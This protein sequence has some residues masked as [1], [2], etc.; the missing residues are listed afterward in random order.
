MPIATP[1]PT[2]LGA[3]YE[4]NESSESSS[5][6]SI[7]TDLPGGGEQAK[8]P[9]P[10]V[11]VLCLLR[12]LLRFA[13]LGAVLGGLGGVGTA[14]LPSSVKAN[15]T[16]AIGDV[17]SVPTV[18]GRLEAGLDRAVCAPAKSELRRLAREL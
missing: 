10:A 6:M 18:L 11:P 14:P 8:R 5:G 12:K 4:S 15:R 1:D 13:S 2:R 7:D 16:E 9:C 3:Q 17:S